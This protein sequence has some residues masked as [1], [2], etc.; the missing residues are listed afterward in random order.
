MAAARLL[1]CKRLMVILPRRLAVNRTWCELCHDLLYRRLPK[2]CLFLAKSRPAARKAARESLCVSL[3][4]RSLKSTPRGLFKKVS[5]VMLLYRFRWQDQTDKRWYIFLFIGLSTFS[6]L[7]GGATIKDV[8]DKVINPT[9]ANTD[10]YATWRVPAWQNGWYDLW[11]AL[12][13]WI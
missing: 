4:R 6:R 12:R 10:G 8:F 11:E 7:E 2:S 9:L 13:T 5:N 1:Q 3:I